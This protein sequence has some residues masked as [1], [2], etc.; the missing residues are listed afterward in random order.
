MSDKM[1]PIPEGHYLTNNPEECPGC[2]KPF[3]VGCYVS[4]IPIGPGEDEDERKKAREGRPYNA[5][6]IPAHY[7]CV[8]GEGDNS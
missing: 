5:I 2:G 8:T 6:A 4:L 3:D 1:G 7:A